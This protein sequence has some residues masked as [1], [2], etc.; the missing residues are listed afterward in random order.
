[1]R[2]YRQTVYSVQNVVV[3]TASP[4]VVVYFRR[5]HSPLLGI[6]A[7]ILLAVMIRQGFPEFADKR[8]PEHLVFTFWVI[9]GTLSAYFL[10]GHSLWLSLFMLWVL[11]GCCGLIRLNH[12]SWYWEIGDDSVIQRRHFRRNVF[13]FSEITYVGPMTGTASEHKY[14]SKHILIRNIAGEKMFVE[15]P[16]CETFLVEMRK[17]LPLI[18][19]NL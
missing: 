6:L 10:Q 13:P 1:M 18:T 17:H 11:L 2:Y 3:F 7:V 9:L 12:R 15:T 19:L 8:I 5:Y 16:Q 14:F 4:I